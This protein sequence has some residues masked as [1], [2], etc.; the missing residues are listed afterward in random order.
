M[1]RVLDTLRQGEGVRAAAGRTA[2][3]GGPSEACVVE[4]TLDEGEVPFV[5]VGGPGKKVELSPSLVHHHPP[6]AKVQPPHTAVEKAAVTVSLSEPRPMAV[7]YEPWPLTADT[8]SITPELIAYH[9]PEHAISQ[10]YA[11]LCAK[12]L[13]SLPGGA[14]QVLLLVGVRPGVGTTTVLL[15]L[16]VTAARSAERRVALL[17]AHWSR[18]ALAARLGYA[19]AGGMHEVLGG[20]LA[21]DQAVLQT[22]LPSL[23]V[24]PAGAI[25]PGAALAPESATWLLAWMRA[26]Y[27]VVLI[28]GPSLEE[29]A[30]V[31]ARAPACDG[32]YLV[33]AQS[34]TPTDRSLL[35]SV[36]RLGGRLRGLIHTRFQA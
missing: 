14:C 1:G 33:L 3:A 10:E 23:R 32:M 9:Q 34:A 13:A 7:S 19:A 21:L 17:D 12:M 15:N 6:Q 24:C 27:D 20:S 8:F 28:D 11:A 5:E 31:A 29:T 30:A 22:P 26:R 4:W 35:Q 36:P 16:A 25:K 2:P 18:P